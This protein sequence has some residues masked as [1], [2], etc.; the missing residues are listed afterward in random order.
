MPKVLREQT[1]HLAHEG[2]PGM[3]IMKQRL[4]A[5]VWW[6][7]LDMQVEKYVKSCR[8]CMLVA[9]PSAPEPMK[10]REQ[11]SAPWQHVAMDFLGPLPSGHTLLVVVDYYS[12]YKEVEIMK[13]SDSSET[14]RRQLAR[15]HQKTT[16]S[17]HATTRRRHQLCAND[18]NNKHC[19]AQNDDEDKQIQEQ[20]TDH[21]QTALERDTCDADASSSSS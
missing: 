7:K 11:P 8:G 10:R 13:K 19:Y 4:R 21:T 9:T 1:L 16:P 2:H 18:D 6:P 17:Q 15:Q 12:R 14:I 20:D 5:M 3:T